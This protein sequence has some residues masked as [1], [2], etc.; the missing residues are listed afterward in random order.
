MSEQT[1][2]DPSMLSPE[3][4]AEFLQSDDEIIEH[5]PNQESAEFELTPEIEAIIMEKVRDINADGIAFT[6]TKKPMLASILRS[7]LIG[8]A[9][10][11]GSNEEH[12]KK[13]FLRMSKERLVGEGSKIWFNINGRSAKGKNP[14]KESIYGQS[15]EFYSDVISVIFDISKFREISGGAYSRYGMPWRE[16]ENEYKDRF[17]KKPRP[18][19]HTF[20]NQ[21]KQGAIIEPFEVQNVENNENNRGTSENA[22]DFGFEAP[23]RI[24]PRFFTGFAM[25]GKITKQEVLEMSS[26]ILETDKDNPKL[27][28]PIYDDSGNLLWPKQMS[29]EEVKAFVAERDKNQEI[30][31]D[32][33]SDIEGQN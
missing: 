27:L 8:G 3:D 24:A 20:S 18:G 22:S 19:I 12:L 26:L 28:V 21:N 32:Q 1:P 4:Q 14:L 31:D 13:W 9:R 33:V 15:A 30:S 17:G 16:Y 23:F 5:Q 25:H 29:Y 7:G 2:I 11:S 6:T 10:G